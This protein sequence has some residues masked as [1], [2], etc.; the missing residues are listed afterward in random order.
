MMPSTTYDVWRYEPAL[1]DSRLLLL[2]SPPSPTTCRTCGSSRAAL[3]RFR[4][5]VGSSASSS[6]VT[7]SLTPGALLSRLTILPATVMD[8]WTSARSRSTFSL[9]VARNPR[10][11]ARVGLKSGGAH[12]ERHP[13]ACG[14]HA[15]E[16]EKAALVGDRS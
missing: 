1:M 15:G 12:L 9:P 5:L 3:V 8:S 7:L 10:D 4:V 14:I 11:V 16:S 2:P 6:P 13:G